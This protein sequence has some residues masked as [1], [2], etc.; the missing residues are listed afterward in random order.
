MRLGLEELAFSEILAL[1]RDFQRRIRPRV[2]LG[3]ERPDLGIRAAAATLAEPTRQKHSPM[4]TPYF[5]QMPRPQSK[6]SINGSPMHARLALVQHLPVSSYAT[7]AGTEPAGKPVASGCTTHSTTQMLHGFLVQISAPPLRAHATV[8]AQ[9]GIPADVIIG[10]SRQES[11]LTKRG[12]SGRGGL[13]QLMPATAQSMAPKGR[14]WSRNDVLNP[15][16]ISHSAF[17]T[18]AMPKE[19][20]GQIEY[21]LAAYNAGQAQRTDG[22][23]AIAKK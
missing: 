10:L 18:S 4:L 20:D 13:M 5:G 16:S 11:A 6:S 14:T 1:S 23:G 8:K 19:F 3:S 2:R 15:R 7:E 12:I 21:A 22:D 9:R 17:G